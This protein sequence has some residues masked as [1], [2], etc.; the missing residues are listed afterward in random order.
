MQKDLTMIYLK[1][2]EEENTPEVRGMLK[3]DIDNYFA[4]CDKAGISRPDDY[5]IVISKD[6]TIEVYFA[7][8]YT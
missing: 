7:K 1:Y 3:N 2:A 4:S 8:T 5:N 6:N